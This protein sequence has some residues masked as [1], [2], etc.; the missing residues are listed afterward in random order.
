MLEDFIAK[1]GSSQVGSAVNL[2]RFYS[3]L[4]FDCP[5]DCWEW[6]AGRNSKGYGQCYFQGKQQLT[7]RVAY[8]IKNGP[9]PDNMMVIHSCDN[10]AC[11]NPD[12]LRLGTNQDNMNDMKERGRSHL[13][14]AKG[15]LNPIAKLDDSAVLSIREIYAT[16]QYTQKELEAAYGI[17]QTVISDIVRGI[18]WPHVGGP[19]TTNG[20]KLTARKGER[21][22]VAKLNDDKV[23]DIRRMHAEGYSNRRIAAIMNVHHSNIG[24]VLSGETWS[25]VK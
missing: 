2:A 7:H 25:H 11:C 16:G 15:I 9:I 20:I 19:I 10:R 12:H 8:Q 22:S 6:T 23:R 4:D 13:H 1:F 18:A 24:A 5:S 17:D 14:G 3:N 21:S